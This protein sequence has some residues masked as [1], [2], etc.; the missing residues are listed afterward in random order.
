[1]RPTGEHGGDQ[2]LGVRP[3]LAGPA[4]ESVR[5]PFG[6]TPMGAGHVVRVRAVLAAHVAALMGADALA[7][8]EDL[9]H[10]RGDPHVDLGADE[11]VRNRVEEVMDLDVIVEIDA[12]ASPFRELPVVG[13]QA[14]EG[15]ALDLLEQ[16]SPARAEVCASGARS[17]LHDASAIASLHSA[18]EKKVSRR[19]RPRM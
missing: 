14:G 12:R 11:R 5:R 16:L 9:D 15:V 18:S 6:V 1:M 10:A 3:D 7:A 8:M 19:K 13:G 4:A 2:P 17:S